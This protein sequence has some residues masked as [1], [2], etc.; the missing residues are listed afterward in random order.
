MTC[1]P[2]RRF[3]PDAGGGV[4]AFARA[5]DRSAASMAWTSSA[6]GKSRPSRLRSLAILSR[7]V[8]TS[9]VETTAVP[10]I[11][12]RVPITKAGSNTTQQDGGG[13][14]SRPPSDGVPGNASGSK[15]AAAGTSPRTGPPE[16]TEP[17]K[18]PS[19]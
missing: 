17:G 16:T 6:N 15:R 19:P 9:I 13:R 12:A 8:L 4:K 2:A 5:S 1:G 7:I 18:S 3:C 11:A 14:Q 10:S